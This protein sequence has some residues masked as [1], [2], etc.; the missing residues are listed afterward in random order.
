MT[1]PHPRPVP[2][3]GRVLPREHTMTFSTHTPAAARETAP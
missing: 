1:I 3:P 2:R